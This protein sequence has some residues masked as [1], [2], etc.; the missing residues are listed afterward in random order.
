MI[1][2]RNVSKG[3]YGP[4]TPRRGPGRLVRQRERPGHLPDRL[5]STGRR[6]HPATVRGSPG[7]VTSTGG[8]PSRAYHR[9]LGHPDHQLAPLRGNER[10]DGGT[11]QSDQE[12]K[13]SSVR[14][15]EL[16]QLQNP[17]TPIRRETQL[18]TPRRH[19]SPVISDDPFQYRAPSS[20]PDHSYHRP[21]RTICRKIKT[22]T[23]QSFQ[24]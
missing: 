9:S 24:S 10:A 5:S 1:V 11:E 13:T 2:V 18:E 14:V 7:P 17:S 4:L 22:Q 19:H 23:T 12:D 20:E 8:E 21:L 6:V 16:R 3:C 15:P